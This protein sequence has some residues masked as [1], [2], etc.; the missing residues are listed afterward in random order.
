MDLV[1]IQVDGQLEINMPLQTFIQ[2]V[3]IHSITIVMYRE[4]SSGLG[5][6]VEIRE[7][8]ALA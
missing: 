5:I 1:D 4:P 8:K 6:V 7:D 3:I 2:S